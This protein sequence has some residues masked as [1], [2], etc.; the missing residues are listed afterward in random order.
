MEKIDLIKG[1]K[2]QAD[3]YILIPQAII[4]GHTAIRADLAEMDQA[5]NVSRPFNPVTS[6]KPK[7]FA[8]FRPILININPRNIN[9]KNRPSK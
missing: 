2:I 1:C 9:S 8:V 7:K 4:A 6:L 3:R 5:R